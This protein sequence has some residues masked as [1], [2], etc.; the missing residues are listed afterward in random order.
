MRFFC[1]N[2]VDS[3]VAAALRE[4]GHEAW[5]AAEAGLAASLDDE[6]TVYAQE[7]A[8]VLI[9]HD[10]EFSNRRKR[11]V[12]GKHVF[13]RC[14]EWDAADLLVE[15]LEVLVKILAASDDLWASVSKQGV[16]FS[17]EWR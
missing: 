5:T 14:N 13:M 17:H 2:D 6:L 15:H 1:D 10:R 8:A 9:T 7:H 3:A 12:V 11:N 16:N 4:W